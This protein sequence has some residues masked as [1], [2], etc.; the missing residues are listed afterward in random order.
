MR[1]LANGTT[2]PPGLPLLKVLPA[3]TPVTQPRR[4]DTMRVDLVVVN[5]T[6]NR[7]DVIPQKTYLQIFQ[8]RFKELA[9]KSPDQLS[10]SI[11]HRA[12]SASI[13]AAMGSFRTKTITSTTYGSGSVDIVGAGGSATGTYSGT[14][15]TTTT[16]PD[17]AARA[18]SAAQIAAIEQRKETAMQAVHDITL[19]SNTLFP[20]QQISGAMFFEREKNHTSMVLSVPLAGRTFQF[21]F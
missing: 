15:T 3:Q 8:P 4:K 5:R 1:P 20:G 17:E 19:R 6:P 9:Y 21:V 10:A 2:G 13:L 11:R 16:M 18:Q 7:V 12:A 14:A